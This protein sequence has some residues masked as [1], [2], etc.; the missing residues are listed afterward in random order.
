[1]TPCALVDRMHCLGGTRCLLYLWRNSPNRAQAATYTKNNKHKRQTSSGIGTRDPS[2]RAAVDLRLRTHKYL[3]RPY[4]T[5]VS[6]AI[7]VAQKN[8]I[9]T[10]KMEVA[11]STKTFAP[12]Y[13]SAK[14]PVPIFRV[15]YSTVRSHRCKYLTSHTT[16][17]F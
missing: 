3:F 9:S 7:Y 5:T 1:M 17:R 13:V 16:D 6:C 4:L 10:L 14:Y 8:H 11:G 15:Y 12:I 2:N